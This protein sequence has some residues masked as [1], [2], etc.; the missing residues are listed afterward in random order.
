MTVQQRA[1]DV[2]NEK[3]FHNDIF[4]D[5]SLREIRLGKFY[6]LQNDLIERYRKEIYK[7]SKKGSSVIEIGCGLDETIFSSTIESQNRYAID[8]SE[9]A[10][11]KQKAKALEYGMRFNFFVMDAH[12][13]EFED[14]SFD[15]VF[16]SSILHHLNLEESLTELR[17]ILKPEGKLIFF[18]PLGINPL[19]NRF[20]NKT[21]ELRTSDEKPFDRKD[22]ELIRSKFKSVRFEFFDLTTLILP[23]IFGH[24]FNKKIIP[25]FRKIDSLFF[26]IN[27]FLKYYAWQVL[28]VATK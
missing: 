12:K 6:L 1:V 26:L 10:I 5:S 7:Y 13:T 4:R 11:E 17:R 8:I 23:V 27:P 2:Q 16:G 22:L 3:K 9:V 15:L 24:H 20:R 28:I 25:L 21:P 18:E 14:S 19:I